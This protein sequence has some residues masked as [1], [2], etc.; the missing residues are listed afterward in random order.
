MKRIREICEKQFYNLFENDDSNEAFAMMSELAT[1][2]QLMREAIEVSF[3][4]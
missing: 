2:G 3:H 1:Q 4:N